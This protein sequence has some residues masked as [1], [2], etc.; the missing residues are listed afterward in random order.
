MEEVIGNVG[1][2][3]TLEEAMNALLDWQE[4]DDVD[5]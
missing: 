5:E 4:S 3:Q 2:A 1:M